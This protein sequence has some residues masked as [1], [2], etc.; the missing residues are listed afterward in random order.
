MAPS[1]GQYM[2]FTFLN[3]LQENAKGIDKVIWF[4]QGTDG[5][6]FTYSCNTYSCNIYSKNFQNSR[7]TG[8]KMMRYSLSLNLLQGCLIFM[9]KK[10]FTAI[11]N[12][13]IFSYAKTSSWQ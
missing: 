7:K 9:S 13:Q 8:E 4:V 12:R 11:L 1:D 5:Y 2:N 10:L 6:S 3:E